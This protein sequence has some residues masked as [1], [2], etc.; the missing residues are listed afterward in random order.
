VALV[1]DSA[2]L[3]APGME[4]V[5]GRDALKIAAQQ[6]F[7]MMTISDFNIIAQELTVHGSVAYELATYSETLQVGD[8]DPTPV[9]GRYLLVWRQEADG[10]WRVDRNMFHFITPA[11][12]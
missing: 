8:G 1:T 7:E 12:F 2:V 5:R 9:R 3:F 10:A 6:M 4:E 11:P